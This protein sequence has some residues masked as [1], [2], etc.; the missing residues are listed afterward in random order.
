MREKILELLAARPFQPFRI[1]LSNGL[2]HMV[3]HPEQALI[4]SSYLILGVPVND[5]PGQAVGDTVFL[6]L[7]H[8]VQVQPLAPAVSVSA[9]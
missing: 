4:T 9:N 5:A 7:I 8:V 3:R 2:V 1:H 6:S